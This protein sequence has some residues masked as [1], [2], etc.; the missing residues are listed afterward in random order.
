MPM[1]MMVTN[2]SIGNL[3][4]YV[5][6]YLPVI[7]FYVMCTDLY[8]IYFISE[9]CWFI[10]RYLFQP[11]VWSFLLIKRSDL[12]NTE[13]LLLWTSSLH[14]LNVN[15]F[16]YS[17]CHAGSTVRNSCHDADYKTDTHAIADL[18]VLY[19]SQ[20]RN[21]QDVILVWYNTYFSLWLK[22]PTTMNVYRS[23][24]QWWL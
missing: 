16:T 3:C 9:H 2:V 1:T 15:C 23:R 18:R 8:S 10:C 6:N 13:Y 22:C 5:V 20:F 12:V 11:F 19:H 21:H 7:L 17:F 24:M 4:N 14:T